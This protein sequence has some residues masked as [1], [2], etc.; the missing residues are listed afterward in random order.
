MQSDE[1]KMQSSKGTLQDSLSKSLNVPDSDPYF[2]RARK[3][4]YLVN[5][6]NR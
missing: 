2:I 4:K 1:T 3:L 6:S 5:A